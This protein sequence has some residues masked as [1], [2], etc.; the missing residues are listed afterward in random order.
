MHHHLHAFLL[1]TEIMLKGETHKGQ[2]Q[3]AAAYFP[4]TNDIA[5]NV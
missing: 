5:L 3:S 1:R 4:V 2:L